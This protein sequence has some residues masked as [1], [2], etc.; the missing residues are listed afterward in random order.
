[1]KVQPSR[2]GRLAK[3]ALTL[4]LC[5]SASGIVFGLDAAPAAAETPEASAVNCARELN[6]A[7]YWTQKA[8][9]AEQ[10][11]FSDST[12]THYYNVAATHLDRWAAGGC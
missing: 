12:V 6:L 5:V 11:M 8:T 7:A 9:L 2:R 3:R 10:F 1:M 4:A